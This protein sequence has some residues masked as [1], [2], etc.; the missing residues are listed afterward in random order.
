LSIIASASAHWASN[1]EDCPWW[2]TWKTAFVASLLLY[3][4]SVSLVLRAVSPYDHVGKGDYAKAR[5]ILCYDYFN[6]NP[7]QVLKSRYLREG[8]P[9]TY[10]VRGKEYLQQNDKALTTGA[11]FSCSKLFSYEQDTGS[12][13]E[14][15]SHS[16]C[17]GN[18]S[19][20]PTH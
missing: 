14:S 13:N 15:N 11:R 1:R 17:F 19:F 9:L 4:I 16:G 7:I 18:S 6:T 20:A 5:S 3:L 2:I 8:K 12:D 10:F